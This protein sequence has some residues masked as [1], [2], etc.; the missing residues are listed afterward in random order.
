M[1]MSADLHGLTEFRVL[2]PQS[3]S[4]SFRPRIPEHRL[5][6]LVNIIFLN[7]NVHEI[8]KNGVC[9]VNQYKTK[10]LKI[11]TIVRKSS[12]IQENT[13]KINTT[14]QDLVFTRAARVK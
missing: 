11:I 8:K 1:L 14:Q 3:N 4:Y 10:V 6:I 13:S 12:E 7:T 9:R 5:L 2:T